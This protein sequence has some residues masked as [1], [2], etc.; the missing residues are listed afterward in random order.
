[1]ERK[2]FKNWHLFDSIL[3]CVNLQ[4]LQSQQQ[5]MHKQNCKDAVETVAV[6]VLSIFDTYDTATEL[7]VAL[8]SFRCSS[9]LTIARDAATGT[10]TLEGLSVIISNLP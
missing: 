2:F 10:P 8:T 3:I 6:V 1:M 7:V 4:M 9:L 5:V